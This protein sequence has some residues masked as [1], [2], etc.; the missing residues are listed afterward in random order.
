MLNILVSVIWVYIVFALYRLRRGFVYDITFN[1]IPLLIVIAFTEWWCNSIINNTITSLVVVTLAI[2]SI[3]TVRVL[4][5]SVVL[6][7]LLSFYCFDAI[8]IA[9]TIALFIPV[10]ARCLIPQQSHYII[11]HNT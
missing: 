3:Y 11:T 9:L 2:A 4:W 10:E 6:L 1:L 5:V 7:I 8:Y